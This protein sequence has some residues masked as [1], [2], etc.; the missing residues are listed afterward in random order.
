MEE[1]SNDRIDDVQMMGVARIG[2]SK[3][4]MVTSSCFYDIN[5]LRHGDYASKRR[6]LEK[7]LEH[8]L[9]SK[10]EFEAENERM[11]SKLTKAM[12]NKATTN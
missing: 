8:G 3:S 6:V 12:I 11:N 4:F 1:S 9:I 10:Q 5:G 2:D 7:K